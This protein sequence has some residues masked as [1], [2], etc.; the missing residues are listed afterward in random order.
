MDSVKPGTVDLV[1][2]RD[3]IPPSGDIQTFCLSWGLKTS[4]C[5]KQNDS[6]IIKISQLC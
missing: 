5:W 2:F 3:A 6:N 4:F 1:I